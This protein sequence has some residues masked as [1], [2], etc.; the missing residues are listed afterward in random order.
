MEMIALFL[1]EIHRRR[2]HAVACRGK[3][4]GI[5]MRQQSVPG[6]HKGQAVLAKLMARPDILFLNPDGLTVQSLHNLRNRFVPVLLCRLVKH[7]QCP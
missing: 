5:A 3:L 4:S 7:V 2:R 6:L 1:P